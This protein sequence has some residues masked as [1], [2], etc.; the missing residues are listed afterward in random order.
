[1]LWLRL[2]AGVRQ[3]DAAAV[4]EHSG[5]ADD[6][7]L[8][9]VEE[10]DGVDC[11][12]A[13]D[14]ARGGA[15]DDLIG[16]DEEACH[17]AE[18]LVEGCAV[19]PGEDDIRAAGEELHDRVMEAPGEE[20]GLVEGD[21]LGVGGEEVFGGI[22]GC[23]GM[24]PCVVGCEVGGVVSGVES[25]FEGDG[26]A[27]GVGVLGEEADEVGGFAGEHGAADHGESGWGL[28][29]VRVVHGVEGYG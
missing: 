26:G 24:K 15:F 16:F 22:D 7:V 2:R 13:A 21:H 28:E 27:S 12:A 1:M 3:V 5:P 29:G 20:V 19:E 23:G 14:R 8:R 18:G 6:D 25:G 17:F 9:G 11:V 10:A 4:L